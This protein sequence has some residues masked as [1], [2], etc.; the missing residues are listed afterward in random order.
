MIHLK[1]FQAPLDYTKSTFCRSLISTLFICLWCLVFADHLRFT[2][3]ASG[4]Q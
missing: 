2:G 1:L 4:L 3:Q